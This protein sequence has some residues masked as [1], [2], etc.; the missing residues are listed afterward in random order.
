MTD[1]TD[2]EI[3]LYHQDANSY[4]VDLRFR[5]P[6]DAAEPAPERGQARFNLA[7]LAQLDLDPIAYGEKLYESLFEDPIVHNLYEQALKTTQGMNKK[8]RLRLFIDRSA[9]ELHDL[10]WETLRNPNDHTWFVTREDVLFSRFLRSPDWRRVRLQPKGQLRAL[11]VIASSSELDQYTRPHLDAFPGAA[12][13]II[14]RTGD[15]L[16]PLDVPA[17]LER[18]RKGLSKLKPDELVSTP[19]TRVTLNRLAAAL[20]EDYNILYLVCHGA[21][22]RKDPK[23]K[24]E[25]YL[26]LEKDDGSVDLLPGAE[27]VERIQDLRQRPQLIVLASCQSAG[28]GQT[29]QAGDGGALAALGPRLAQVGVPAVLAMQGNVY[30]ETLA[31][32]MPVFFEQLGEHGQIDL[33]TATARGMV[34]KKSDWWMPVLFMRLRDGTIWYVPGFTSEKLSF[35]RWPGLINSIKQKRCTPILGSGLIEFMLGTPQ[36]IAR[37]WVKDEHFPLASRYQDEFHQVAQYLA[38]SQSLA[39]PRDT[40]IKYLREEMLRYYTVEL[41][42]LGAD[43][44][45]HTLISEIGRRRR[46][47]SESEPHR[48]LA[49]LDIPVYVNV[50]YDDLLMEALIEAGKKPQIEISRWNS[51]LESQPSL[52]DVEKTYKPTVERPL[53]FYLFG[54]LRDPLSLVLTEDDYFDYLMWVNKTET[55]IPSEVL[56]AW[57]YDALL[58]LGFHMDDWKFRV[59]FRSI[60]NEQRS[61]L[62]RQYNSVA[63]Q[64]NPGEG[65]LQPERARRYLEEYFQGVRIGTYWGSAED[66]T[67]DLWLRW[68]E[69]GGKK[70]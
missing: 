47:A 51:Y 3:G 38:T 34:R 53:I 49:N 11:I 10:R 2:L 20:R 64:I 40:M 54:R 21:F 66:F 32:F 69:K 45:L 15:R 6:D 4:G 58:F 31:E 26:Y 60:L 61:N 70:R 35:E 55:Q 68:K 7:E 14:G 63:V 30:M 50:N 43:A 5:L 65:S 12:A 25:P 56:A 33:A 13:K 62:K 16:A 24:L 9:S 41:Q 22:I 52:K 57:S 67:K 59:L 42:D 17:E 27:L 44:D 37:K 48:V 29:S 18:A 28:Q 23:G 46:Q 19:E 1:Y 8:M 36:D 39:Y